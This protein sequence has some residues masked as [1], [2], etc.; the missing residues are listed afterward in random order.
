MPVLICGAVRFAGQFI[1]LRPAANISPIATVARGLLG[2]SAAGADEQPALTEVPSDMRLRYRI[3]DRLGYDLR[4]K[5]KAPHVALER[6]VVRV[7]EEERVNCVLD[8]GANIG[9]YGAS[10]RQAGY[11]GWIIS[12]EPIA[13]S[14]A[15]LSKK[16]R[17]D[18]RWDCRPFALGKIEDT[19]EIHLHRN[20]ELASMLPVSDFGQRHFRDQFEEIAVEKV[21]IKRLDGLFDELMAFLPEPRVFLKMDTQGYDLEVFA[22]AEH[23]REQIVGLQSECSVTPLYTGM[24]DYLEALSEYRKQGFAV[25]G[26]Y[27]VARDLESSRLVEFDCVMIRS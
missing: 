11:S 23:C 2:S 1:R 6:H 27:P 16:C 12:F 21:T 13:A 14:Y 18:E 22:G 8:V 5:R 3:A 4:K 10:L 24:P 20:S 17:D 26:F 9:Q 7:L 15:E 25:T 19:R